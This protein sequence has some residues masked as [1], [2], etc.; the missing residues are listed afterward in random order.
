MVRD[1]E[2]VVVAVELAGRVRRERQRQLV[3]RDAAAV[4]DHADQ[5]PPAVF[6]FDDDLRRPGVDRILDQFL[7]DRRRPLD[8]LA[9][10]DAVDERRR[11]LLNPAAFHRAGL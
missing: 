4:V 2:Q 6:D 3:R 5:R 7:H 8:H 9:G 10:G 11:Q 1:A